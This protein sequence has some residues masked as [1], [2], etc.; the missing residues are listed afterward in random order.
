MIRKLYVYLIKKTRSIFTNKKKGFEGYEIGD[1]TY[2]NPK[3]LKYGSTT[4]LKIGR[5]CSIAEGVT[6]F[7]GGEH[8]FDWVTS[9]PFSQ[10]FEKARPLP[11]YPFSKGNVVIGNDVWIG[12]DVTILSGVTIGDGAVIGT[13]SLVVKDV[14]PY[15]IVGGVPAKHLKY[16]FSEE[17]I[18]LLQEIQ[19]W[20]WP[21]DKIEE[22][23]PL[24]FS[25]NLDGFLAKYKP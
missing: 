2:G 8:H 7:L 11:G 4:T 1:W 16:R 10:I 22:S 25:D 6:I 15:A 19:W 20:N 21:I 5:F 12:R 24:L 23:W 13:R 3:V 9:Y 18:Q 17:Q 14:A